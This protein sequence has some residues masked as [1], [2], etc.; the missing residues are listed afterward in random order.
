[1]LKRREKTEVGRKRGKYIKGSKEIQATKRIEE[2][3]KEIEIEKAREETRRNL[4]KEEKEEGRT[5]QSENRREISFFF[6]SIWK[7]WCGCCWS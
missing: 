7:G 2:D 1:M 6:F 4:K 3:K 5:Q